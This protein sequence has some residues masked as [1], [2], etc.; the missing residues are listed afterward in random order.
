M[1]NLLRDF[2]YAAR[3]LRK[4]PGFAAIAILMLALAIGANTAI[5]SLISTAFLRPLPFPNPGRLV[6]V[7][8]DTPMFGVKY[9]PPA[10][11]NYT[12]WKASNQVFD[13]M[14]ALEFRMFA[15]SGQG[16]PEVVH[17][18]VVT[19][20]LFQTLGVEP[21]LGRLFL[22][23]EDYPGPAK[24]V[25]LGYGLWRRRY[26]ANPAVIGT[27]TMVNSE[28]YTVVGVMPEGFRFPGMDEMW[29]PVGTDFSRSEFTN[30]G[31]HNLMVVARLKPGV[32]VARATENL[33]VISGR[34]ARAYP[35]T[36][37]NVSA[38]ATLLREHAAGPVRNLYTI[39]LAAV[40]FVLL[41][42]C[43]N[44]ANLL[45]ARA[46]GRQREIAVR[47]AL[48]AGRR[49]I[50]RQLLAESVLLSALGAALGVLLA[51][52]S[53]HFLVRLIPGEIAAMNA[54]RIDRLALAFTVGLTL[55]TTLAFGA[56]PVAQALRVD[57]NEALK[58]GGARAGSSGRAAAMR[59]AL[60]VCEVA[61]S[62]V[63]L[64]A[65]GLMIQSFSRLRGVD[66]G[67]PPQNLLTMLVMPSPVRYKEPAQ[68]VAFYREVLRRIDA[69][70]G[71]VS[72]GFSIGIP[73]AFKGWYNGVKVEGA[74][75]RAG[76]EIP[77]VNYRV[78]TSDYLQTLRVPLRCGRYL[79]ERD[80]PHA[81]RVAVINETMARKFWPGP[82]GARF[83]LGKRLKQGDW[84][85]AAPWYTVVGVVG[86]IK[87]NGL[88]APPRP[89]M[90]VSYLQQDNVAWGLVIRT[91]TAPERLAAPI[92]RA[93]HAVDPE[94]PILEPM[95][96]EQV[97]DREVSHRKLQSTLLGTF[98]A[99]ALLMASL[100]MYGVLSHTVAR[101]TREIGIRLAL[102][103]R[104]GAVL[105]R[106]IV[107]GLELTAAGVAIGVV[108]AL[109]LTR[110][111]SSLLYG[112]SARDPWT[113]GGTALLMLAI[114]VLASALPARRAM[115]V[116]PIVALRE[117]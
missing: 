48:G 17:G 1:H 81:P 47:A 29:A 43:A 25:I 60:V 109:A 107:Q 73:V 45:L 69:L 80:G 78:V 66:P 112:V 87:S 106:V 68:R 42:A 115:R 75:E 113:I 20:S 67:F 83:A 116:D 28:K 89:E 21:K 30:R 9:S 93:I 44:L 16:E 10:M 77:T 11:G 2:R 85:P 39:L 23:E 70:P 6:A 94:Q 12:E 88:D 50:A 79:E 15:L 72:A 24:T 84:S 96:M 5:F 14:G 95:T 3:L 36:N 7:W 55:V 105:R 4:S 65:A 114:S 31:R 13:N 18:S 71:V 98:S 52:W 40:G 56:A 58:Q 38:F 53:T 108:A 101:R 62:L 57:L 41:I 100:G 49:R 19:A 33:R 35:E 59:N 111:L 37:T 97:L 46:A 51:M 32:T 110:A 26:S 103:A 22:P 90:Y 102:G 54:L 104:P 63:L 76:G 92:R 86:D 82:G 74:A 61:L 91:A 8:E 27:E 64:A 34:L 99:L 117:E